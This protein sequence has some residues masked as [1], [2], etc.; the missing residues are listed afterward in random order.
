MHKPKIKIS[1]NAY[2]Y[3]I[4]ALSDCKEYDCIKFKFITKCCGTKIDI[5]LDNIFPNDVCEKIDELT[6]AYDKT[7]CN[8]VKEI[9]ITYKNNSLAIKHTIIEGLLPK[10]KGN[11]KKDK[12]TSV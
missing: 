1:Y 7:L 11:C 5:I 3:F 4:K 12:T 6:V 2:D 8:N 9:I 10:L